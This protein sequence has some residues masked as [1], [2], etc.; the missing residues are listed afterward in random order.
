MPLKHSILAALMGAVL[1]LS[2]C[3]S[4]PVAPPEPPP[5]AT[6]AAPSALPVEPPLPMP[7]GLEAAT[8]GRIYAEAENW[9]L[10]IDLATDQVDRI[11]VPLQTFHRSVTAFDHGLVA[12]QADTG[13]GYLINDQGQTQELPEALR[14][15]GRLYWAGGDAIWAPAEYATGNRRLVSLFDAT[16]GELLPQGASSPPDELGVPRPPSA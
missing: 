12:K 8:T 1:W 9:V 13:T 3:T 7:P 2:A 11:A 15:K 5:P 16:S 10:R 6:S 4:A 14:G